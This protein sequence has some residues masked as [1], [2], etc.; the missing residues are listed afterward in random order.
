MALT[1]WVTPG[2]VQNPH[3]ESVYNSVTNTWDINPV[4]VSPYN[5]GTLATTSQAYQNINVGIPTTYNQYSGCPAGHIMGADGVCRLDPNWI[6]AGTT[7]PT[8]PTDPTDPDPTIP[9]DQTPFTPS[10]VYQGVTQD[11]DPDV[12]TAGQW[13]GQVTGNTYA[14]LKGGWNNWS[15]EAFYDYGL[16]KGYFTEAGGLV[17]AMQTTAEGMIGSLGQWA[18]DKKFQAWLSDAQKK[19]IF[20]LSYDTEGVLESAK[21]LKKRGPLANEWGGGMLEDIAEKTKETSE[22]IWQSLVAEPFS[23]DVKEFPVYDTRTASVPVDGTEEATKLALKATNDLLEDEYRRQEEWNAT[24]Y[25]TNRSGEKFG[26]GSE[27]GLERAKGSQLIEDLEKE[28]AAFEEQLETGNF[29]VIQQ[30]QMF[31]P[32]LNKWVKKSPGLMAEKERRGRSEKLLA[33][34]EAAKKPAI[35]EL[36]KPAL[37][38]GT[39]EGNKANNMI[40]AQSGQYVGSSVYKNPDNGHYQQD[41]KFVFDSNGDGKADSVASRGS[42]SDS[43]YAMANGTAVDSVLDRTLK[44]KGSVNVMKK[45]AKK[46]K[47]AG[48]ITEEEYN[49]VT[50]YGSKNDYQ[51]DSNNKTIH[52]NG[53][54]TSGSDSSGSYAY[55]DDVSGVDISIPSS[56]SSSGDS[57]SGSESSSGNAGSTGSSSKKDK[58]ICTE[59]YRQTNLDDWKEA[60]KLWYL[61]QKK[62]LTS[63]H[64]VGYHFLFKPFVRGMKKSRILTAIGSHFA[65]QRTKD[66]KYI[67]FGT[68]FSL[69]GRMYRIIFEPIC[70]ITGLLLTYKERRA[71][72]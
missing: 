9:E 6:G 61:F 49:K 28:K 69:L 67:M 59:M 24:G 44:D 40:H 50:S 34:M 5:Y 3:L 10:N 23:R 25:Y 27:I 1:P 57:S 20:E 7:T 30:E 37:L 62:Y 51:S 70:Y 17:G 39:V 19:G 64:Q 46:M 54:V 18:N 35:Q 22:Q 41:G 68:K 26:P 42:M 47:D 63:T 29:H 38:I 21:L 2:R 72:Q 66:I 16:D 12:G 53:S 58:I 14:N 48:K 32:L 8:D 36:K 43:I 33:E 13:T 71:W 31:D 55:G 56:G 52:E 15:D 45:E 65:K 4:N 11:A 60:M